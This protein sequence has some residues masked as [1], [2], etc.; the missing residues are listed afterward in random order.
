M[1][2]CVCVCVSCAP[3]L[4]PVHFS[5]R[6]THPRLRHLFAQNVHAPLESPGGKYDAACAI[7][8]DSDRRTFCAMAA[9]ADEAIGNVTSLLASTFAGEDYLVVV[10]G[11]N[12]GMPMSAGN[13]YPLRGHKAELWEGGIRNNA[14]V[15]G[16]LVPADRRGTTYTGGLIH[17][18][19][20]HATFAALG[21]GAGGSDPAAAVADAKTLDGV[22]VWDALTTGGPSPRNEFLIN[23]DPCSG[24]GSCSGI[25]YGYRFGDMKLMVGTAS[26]TWYPVPQPD[27]G[28]DTAAAAAAAHGLVHDAHGNVF[29]TDERHY[30]AAADG[31]TWL[32]NITADPTERTNLANNSQYADMISQL[33]AKVNAIVKG[34]DYLAPCNIPTGSCYAD[35]AAGAKAAKANGGWY[36]WVTSAQ[37]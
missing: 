8:P 27:D 37:Q 7:V 28:D 6:S 2:V 10:A 5:A 32:F 23:Y 1:C 17:V 35:D 14:I 11:D 34:D 25:E 12:G 21:A 20:W 30:A 26:D 3:P 33:T 9:I 24:H 29:W 4:C 18:M 15:W 22:A 31:T 16:S 13:N 19:D 36:P